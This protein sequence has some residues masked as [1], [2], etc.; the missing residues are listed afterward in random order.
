M[1]SNNGGVVANGVLP[2]QQMHSYSIP[3]LMTIG[4]RWIKKDGVW[5]KYWKHD[6]GTFIAEMPAYF[7]SYSVYYTGRPFDDS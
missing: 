1:T 7:Q 2:A 4:C 3:K 6:Y 5:W